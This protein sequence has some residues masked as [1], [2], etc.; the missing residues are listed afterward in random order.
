MAREV[1]GKQA[2]AKAIAKGKGK[3]YIGKAI[4]KGLESKV[5]P[6]AIPKEKAPLIGGFFHSACY[7]FEINFISHASVV[8]YASPMA[9]A[10]NPA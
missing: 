5:I 4:G 10:A 8:Q 6:K 2:K 9:S 1:P 7:V 3:N